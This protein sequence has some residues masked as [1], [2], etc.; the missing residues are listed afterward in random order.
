[1]RGGEDDRSLLLLP[2]VRARRS[3]ASVARAS[4]CRLVV[5]RP[6]WLAARSKGGH[7]YFLES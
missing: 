6:F 7:G 2:S 5:D 1:M 3:V 4:F